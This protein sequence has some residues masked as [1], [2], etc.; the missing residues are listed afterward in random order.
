MLPKLQYISQGNSPEEHYLH[1]QQ[2]LDAGVKWIQLRIKHS[3]EETIL[4]VAERVKVLCDNYEATF[5][6]NDFPEIAKK[7]DAS[8]VHLGLLDPNVYEAR[9]LLGSSKII[10]GTANTWEHVVQRINERCNY[11][12]L[13]PYA[14]TSTKEKLSPI[15][16]I[17]GYTKILS[18]L[19]DLGV[20]IPVIAIGGIGLSDVPSLLQTGIHGIAVSGM[21]TSKDVESQVSQLT[22]LLYENT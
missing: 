16:G 4:S 10:G 3:Q 5:I 19:K 12:G 22:Q 17:S 1:I 15:L 21:L 7:V 8:G 13:G 18:E 20:S 11:V 6:V 9:L 14:F 2:V